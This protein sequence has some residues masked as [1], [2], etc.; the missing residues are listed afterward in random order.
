MQDNQNQKMAPKEFLDML[1]GYGLRMD[2]VSGGRHIPES[3]AKIKS[4]A[5]H[6]YDVSFP[7]GD[8]VLFFE[9]HFFL[10]TVELTE[11]S[12]KVKLFV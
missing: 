11:K 1:A 5:R 10:K 8:S 6:Q 4:A 7:S 2:V 3:A 9:G 12:L